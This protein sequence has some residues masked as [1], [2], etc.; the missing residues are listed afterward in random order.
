MSINKIII[1]TTSLSIQ[2]IIAKLDIFS[3]QSLICTW[4]KREN[5][6]SII[7]LS[8]SLIKSCPFPNRWTRTYLLPYLGT[9][10]IT[11]GLESSVNSF[12]AE[13]FSFSAASGFSSNQVITSP[14]SIIIPYS[15]CALHA[16]GWKAIKP[17]RSSFIPSFS[18]YIRVVFAFRS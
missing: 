11:T 5:I 8:I 1:Y 6:K 16:L 18:A 3:R 10:I 12:S 17:V 13:S 7:S 14:A 9:V 15:P 4:T 2:F